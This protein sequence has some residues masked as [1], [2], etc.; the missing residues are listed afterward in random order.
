MSVQ[1][2]VILVELIELL[3]CG[4]LIANCGPDASVFVVLIESDDVNLCEVD[5]R[6]VPCE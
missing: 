3:N 5:A 2:I 4:I 6:R 1:G